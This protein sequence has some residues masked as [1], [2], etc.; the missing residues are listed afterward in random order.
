MPLL[1]SPKAQQRGDSLCSWLKASTVLEA[2]DDCRVFGSSNCVSQRTARHLKAGQ[3]HSIK[4]FIGF[5]IAGHYLLNDSLEV[6]G[7][8]LQLGEALQ[9]GCIATFASLK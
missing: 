5:E 7:C 3:C 6:T 9:L 8:W 2:G 4:H 1:G